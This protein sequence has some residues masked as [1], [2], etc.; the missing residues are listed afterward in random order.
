MESTFIFCYGYGCTAV[1]LGDL[2]KSLAI[3][4]TTSS[5]YL[6][7]TIKS[8]DLRSSGLCKKV[9]IEKDGF[10]DRFNH[11]VETERGF[12]IKS[13][14][15]FRCTTRLCELLKKWPKLPMSS[16]FADQLWCLL[17]YG[18]IWGLWNSRN[19]V[20]FRNGGVRIDRIIKD[21]K[22]ILWFWMG[23]HK[24]RRNF[25]FADMMVNWD[26]LIAPL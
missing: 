10:S 22:G 18:I 4:C 26:S 25:F 21:I 11:A 15:E 5:W 17:P 9:E 13:I 23:A 14:L 2:W 20:I 12:T 1:V 16:G 7:P 19:N 8:K 24:D 6:V 3:R